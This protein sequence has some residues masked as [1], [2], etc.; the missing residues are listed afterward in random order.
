MAT[1][2]PSA[3]FYRGRRP[4]I[5]LAVKK[6]KSL[7][8]FEPGY[9]APEAVLLATSPAHFLKLI[10]REGAGDEV[11][12]RRGKNGELRRGAEKQS[13]GKTWSNSRRSPLVCPGEALKTRAGAWD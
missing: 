10:P 4:S 9:L 1:V 12:G 2:A 8:A 3:P 11:R 5:L 13:E 6:K 7:T